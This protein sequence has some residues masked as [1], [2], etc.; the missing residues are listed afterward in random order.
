MRLSVMNV[1]D[2]PHFE[3]TKFVCMGFQ[4]EFEPG[5][6]TWNHFFSFL[7][8]GVLH[9]MLTPK[10]TISWTSSPHAPQQ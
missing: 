6:Y 3:C 8:D 7:C 2:F 5:T 9:T 4:V 10:M 1:K